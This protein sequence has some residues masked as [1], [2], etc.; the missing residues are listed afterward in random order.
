MEKRKDDLKKA[1][2]WSRQAQWISLAAMILSAIA[3]IIRLAA[4]I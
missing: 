3:L 1:K 2:T 4:V